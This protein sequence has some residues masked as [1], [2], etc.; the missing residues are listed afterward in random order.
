M[1][2]K[3][4]IFK[5]VSLTPCNS[6]NGGNL[7]PLLRLKWELIF[8]I[9]NLQT[10]KICQELIFRFMFKSWLFWSIKQHIKFVSGYISTKNWYFIIRKIR[11]S[12]SLSA[13]DNFSYNITKNESSA[14]TG[15]EVQ[16]LHF[17][18]K[19]VFYSQHFS[20]DL[21]GLACFLLCTGDQF[22]YRLQ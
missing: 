1:I 11:R 15:N 9:G 7:D 3:R 2:K 12:I 20:P 5:C 8:V 16:N 10:S 14:H 18:I 13:Q 21:F 17:F 22:H 19:R 6:S 4:P